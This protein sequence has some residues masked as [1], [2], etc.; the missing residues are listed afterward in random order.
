MLHPSIIL[1]AEKGFIDIYHTMPTHS[2]MISTPPPDRLIVLVPN[3]KLD[4]QNFAQQITALS[5]EHII[6]V[7]LLDIIDSPNQKPSASIRLDTLT[8]LLASISISAE[9]RIISISNWLV[10]FPR[11][12]RDND[13]IVCLE[14]HTIQALDG[15]HIPICEILPAVQNHPLLVLSGLYTE[16]Q[17]PQPSHRTEFAWWIIALAFLIIFRR[18]PGRRLALQRP[19]LSAPQFPNSR[20]IL[21]NAH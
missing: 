21:R 3:Q 8:I 14:E 6:P 5:I 10:E 20:R 16:T 2:E 11:I 18:H 7:L 4:E 1:H 12:C 17:L 15:D 13:L 9:S 19:V